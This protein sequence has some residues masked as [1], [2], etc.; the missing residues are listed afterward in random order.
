[1]AGTNSKPIPTITGRD[2]ERFWKSVAVADDSDACWVWTGC[3][4]RAGYGVISISTHGQKAK[5]VYSHRIAVLISTG[6]D[7]VGKHVCHRCDN[8]PCCNP[9]HLFLGSQQ[10]NCADMRSK[11]RGAPP[12]CAYLPLAR[13]AIER[14]RKNR[15]NSSVGP[16]EVRFIREMWESRLFTMEFIIRV[17][18]VSSNLLLNIIH[19]DDWNGVPMIISELRSGE[20][21]RKPYR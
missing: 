17:F 7:P 9:K 10:D 15:N 21:T 6:V 1:M 11:G 5:V 8:P 16:I 3:K 18:S 13:I 4:S 12:P 2:A 19:R 20:R 14:D